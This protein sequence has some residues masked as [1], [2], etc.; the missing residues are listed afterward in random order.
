V[1]SVLQFGYSLALITKP[2]FD[3]GVMHICG[4]MTI[5]TKDPEKLLNFYERVF[6]G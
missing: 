4:G 2:D 3:F 1:G 5:R 6:D